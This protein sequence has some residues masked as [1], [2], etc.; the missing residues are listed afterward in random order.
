MITSSF[1]FTCTPQDNLFNLPLFTWGAREEFARLCR[2]TGEIV[3]SL[4][5]KMLRMKHS[6]F[7]CSPTLNMDVTCFLKLH[8]DVPPLLELEETNLKF[9]EL[10]VKPFVIVRTWCLHLQ[11]QAVQVA[12]ATVPPPPPPPWATVYQWMWCNMPEVMNF[13]QHSCENLKHRRHRLANVFGG[14]TAK[15]C[16]CLPQ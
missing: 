15:K 6:A 8:F 2:T 3:S 9:Q 10:Y 14:V 11:N 4:L 13:H 16:F 12:G 5:V 1:Q 7:R